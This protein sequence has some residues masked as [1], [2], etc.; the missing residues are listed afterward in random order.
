M[1]AILEM[2]LAVWKNSFRFYVQQIMHCAVYTLKV[3]YMVR[4]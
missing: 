3:F 1:K 2:A 4:I